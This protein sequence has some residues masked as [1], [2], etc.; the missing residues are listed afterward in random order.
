VMPYRTVN[1]C[2]GLGSPGLALLL[3]LLSPAWDFGLHFRG[4]LG[5]VGC[6]VVSTCLLFIILVVTY[7]VSVHGFREGIACHKGGI[8]A[9]GIDIPS[10][11]FSATFGFPPALYR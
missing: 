7:H 2:A 5:D 10:N 11:C 1:L 9:D 6:G 3:C 8:E 4:G